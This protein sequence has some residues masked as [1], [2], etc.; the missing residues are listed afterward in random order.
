MN[1]SS[2]GM[3]RTIF[4]VG[5]DNDLQLWVIRVEGQP[6]AAHRMKPQAV[7]QASVMA[8]RLWEEHRIP[9]QIVVSKLDGKWE[10]ERT[11]PDVTPESPG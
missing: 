2:L 1:T 10:E 4:R 3:R 6:I 5:F 11:Y 8:R 9:T 7:G